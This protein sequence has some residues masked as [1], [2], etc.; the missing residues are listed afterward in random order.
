MGDDVRPGLEAVLERARLPLGHAGSTRRPPRR[1]PTPLQRPARNKPSDRAVRTPLSSM[2]A[3]RIPIRDNRSCNR[4]VPVLRLRRYDRLVADSRLVGFA[5]ENEGV[6]DLAGVCSEGDARGRYQSYGRG[7][8]QDRRLVE[9]QRYK[10]RSGV[11]LL[12]SLMHSLLAHGFD[13]L[14]SIDL[15]CFVL[16]R[17]C[18]GE[19]REFVRGSLFIV[20]RTCLVVSV[21]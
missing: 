3:I 11:L 16:S 1:P 17:I 13:E 14:F 4:A 20:R 21:T 12:L 7:V 5:A 9:R 6:S 10:R 8:F 15:R 19:N 18:L 2:E